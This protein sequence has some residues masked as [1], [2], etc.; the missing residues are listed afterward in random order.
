MIATDT[1]LDMLDDATF[2]LWAWLSL[3][4]NAHLHQIIEADRSVPTQTVVDMLMMAT[5][6][7]YVH[8]VD[9]QTLEDR[10]V[11][12]RPLILDAGRM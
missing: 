6:D 4:E 9:E 5:D 11:K 7:P 1:E 10:I 8:D 3:L 2:N 12:I